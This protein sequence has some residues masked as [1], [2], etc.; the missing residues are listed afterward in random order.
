MP[1]TV[2]MVDLER[3]NRRYTALQMRFAALQGR[4]KELQVQKTRLTTDISLAKGR[5]ELA[6]QAAEVFNYLQEQAHARAVGEFEDL[7]SAF[8]RSTSCSITAGIW[9]TSSRAT[10]VA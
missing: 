5:I 10:A 2:A 3:L 9:R 7:L 8:R 4:A 1:V 6:P